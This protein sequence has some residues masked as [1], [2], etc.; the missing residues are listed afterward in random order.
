[1][2]KQIRK[3]FKT[4]KNTQIRLFIDDAFVVNP[5]EYICDLAKKYMK[6]RDHLFMSFSKNEIYG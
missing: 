1:M 6:G 3:K 2:Q 4:P 5:Q